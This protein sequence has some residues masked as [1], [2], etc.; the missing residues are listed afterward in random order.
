MQTCLLV[1]DTNFH[2]TLCAV[3]KAIRDANQVPEAFQKFCGWNDRLDGTTELQETFDLQLGLLDLHGRRDFQ[4]YR[5]GDLSRHMWLSVSTLI[6]QHLF[7]SS[8]IQR[9]QSKSLRWLTV[10]AAAQV[11]IFGVSSTSTPLNFSVVF[12]TRSRSFV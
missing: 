10:L 9:S 2:P 7:F 12:A 6:I 1:P 5:D 8:G 3:R 11:P 4:F